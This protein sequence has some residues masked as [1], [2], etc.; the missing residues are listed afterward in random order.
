MT[1]SSAIMVRYF[2]FDLEAPKMKVLCG[3]P[4]HYCNQ[5][6]RS[7]TRLV[8]ESP[9]R[10]QNDQAGMVL[11]FL[12]QPYFVEFS[13]LT[14]IPRHIVIHDLLK[15]APMRDPNNCRCAINT[16]PLV[17]GVLPNFNNVLL[18]DYQIKD[19]HHNCVEFTFDSWGTVDKDV[20][21]RHPMP[22]IRLIETRNARENWDSDDDETD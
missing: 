10:Y 20:I 4:R 14:K 9:M 21:K 16:V 1:P 11:E 17:S 18:R 13:T 7:T 12:V 3:P 8:V 2:T 22:L 5:D 19:E 15:Y 6:C